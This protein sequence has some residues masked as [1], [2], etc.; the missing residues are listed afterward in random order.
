MQP[1]HSTVISII[2]DVDKED[3]KN[4]QWFGESVSSVA[5]VKVAETSEDHFS[6]LVDW[7]CFPAAH[8]VFSVRRSISSSA[9]PHHRAFGMGNKFRENQHT[10]DINNL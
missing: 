1:L 10:L 9:A 8:L 5:E 2:G 3:E 7:I 4:R 6:V